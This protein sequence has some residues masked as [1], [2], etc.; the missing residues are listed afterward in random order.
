MDDGASMKG[1][2]RPRRTIFLLRALGGVLLGAVLGASGTTVLWACGSWT[3]P[4][5]Y[6]AGGGALCGALAGG[7]IAVG[8]VGWM[9]VGTLLGAAAGHSF[10]PIKGLPWQVLLG[11]GV[12]LLLGLAMDV[13]SALR[14]NAGQT[15]PRQV[16]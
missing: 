11:A 3:V 8:E 16:Q 10:T 13:R 1:G 15:E 14:V 5:G 6:A 12:G 7:F 2:P 4:V 9:F